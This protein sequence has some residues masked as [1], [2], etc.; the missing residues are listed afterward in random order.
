MVDES[1]TRIFEIDAIL[2]GFHRDWSEAS[3][4]EMPR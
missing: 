3:G 4:V 1:S 2:C